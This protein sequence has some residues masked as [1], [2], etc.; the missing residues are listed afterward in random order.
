MLSG[1]PTKLQ[2]AEV[3]DWFDGRAAFDA[4]HRTL[5]DEKEI[6]ELISEDET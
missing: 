4:V 2:R 5:S 1:K 6:W 3:L